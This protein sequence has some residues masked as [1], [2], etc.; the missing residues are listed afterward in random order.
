[1]GTA[2]TKHVQ[3]TLKDGVL[4]IMV[5][6]RHTKESPQPSRF[7]VKV[8]ST[9]APVEDI[10]KDESIRLTFDFP[11]VKVADVK[12]F[13]D[14]GK[15]ILDAERKRMEGSPIKFHR[16]MNLDCRVVDTDRVQAFLADGVL[17]LILCRKEA[18]PLQTIPISTGEDVTDVHNES[19]NMA[20]EE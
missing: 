1:M 8:E 2:D 11:G 14:D 12:V 19:E 4:T 3:A 15:L 5:P 10:E 9:D 17:T 7:E 16:T 18:E 6:K 13:I 20:C